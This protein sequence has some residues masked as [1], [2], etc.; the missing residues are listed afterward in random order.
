MTVSHRRRAATPSV[1]NLLYGWARSTTS[2]F[3]G[4]RDLDSRWGS[5]CIPDDGL[6]YKLREWPEL[7]DMLRTAPVLRM[8]SVMSHRPVNRR[9]M[10]GQNRVTGEMVDALLVRLVNQGA[11]QVIDTQRFGERSPLTDR[12]SGPV[13]SAQISSDHQ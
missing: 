3:G 10:V 5:D 1:V 9:W 12:S 4:L 2:S 11:V 6:A 7:P 13:P 8:L